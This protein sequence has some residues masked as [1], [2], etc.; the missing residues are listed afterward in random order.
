[1][2]KLNSAELWELFGG[3]RNV[4]PATLFPPL[5]GLTTSDPEV[6]GNP[7]DGYHVW[8]KVAHLE[9]VVLHAQG[10]TFLCRCSRMPILCACSKF[11]LDCGFDERM[12]CS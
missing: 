3:G 12:L 4:D 9:A 5:S 8:L 10:V 2:Q 1:M 6:F 11:F 7:L